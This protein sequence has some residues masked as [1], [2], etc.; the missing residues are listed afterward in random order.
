MS[1]Y[2]SMVLGFEEGENPDWNSDIPEWVK[3]DAIEFETTSNYFYIRYDG[4]RE[5]VVKKIFEELES[6]QRIMISSWN[7]TSDMGTFKLYDRKDGGVEKVEDITT[8]SY[9]KA[10]EPNIQGV[11]EYFEEDYGF[12][13]RFYDGDRITTAGGYFKIDDDGKKHI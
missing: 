3:S 6:V 12:D 10:F 8:K 4:F 7:D 9:Y 1:S 11:S 13:F 5:E 2:K